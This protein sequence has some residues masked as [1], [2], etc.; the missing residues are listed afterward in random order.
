MIFSS[1]T[2]VFLFLPLTFV[3][4]L[5]V[6]KY[7][8]NA[9]LLIASLIFYAWGE[10]IFVLLML[11][12]GFVNYLFALHLKGDKKL[13]FWN[14]FFNIGLLA[15]F[16]Y[17]DFLIS[18]F[19]S[20]FSLSI[21]LLGLPLPVGISFYTFQTM[22]YTID[23]YRREIPPQKN[24]FDLLLYITFFPQ[25]IAGPIVVYKDIAE[26]I[27]NRRMTRKDVAQGIERFVYGLAKKLII[28]N[29]AALMVDK[30][31]A[32]K[33]GGTL[34]AWVAAVCYMLQIYYDFSG[35][36]D[37]AIGMGQMFGFYFKENF[38]YPYTATSIVN[39]WRRW[40][41]SLS[42]WFLD[43]VYIPLG[44]NRK[45]VSR[46]VT[47]KIFV[48]FLTGIWHGAAW[49]FI[50]WGLYHGFFLLLE[51]LFLKP[52]KWPKVL[53]HT[54]VIIVVMVG[55]VL[56]RSDTF[57]QA[58]TFIG[59]M[60]YYV[61]TGAASLSVVR[62]L[63]TPYFMFTMFWGILFSTPLIRKFHLNRPSGYIISA[64]VWILCLLTLSATTYN[65]FIY[66]RF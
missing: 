36:S 9:V 26:Q 29:S 3:L 58:F 25:L 46:E 19:N 57:L 27:K 17:S 18:T 54:Y 37:M 32:L 33:D 35:Y 53:C 64:A 65:P 42:S 28:A 6:P 40:H 55:F 2:F 5:I 16:K 22:S 24:F 20:I 66:F 63:S 43:Y 34:S 39:F 56:F 62:S 4:T 12:C 41:I 61:P 45:G 47:N 44:G 52:E 31:F 51:K 60:F 38:H 11:F 23:V 15:V 30:L 8:R 50:I 59:N 48:F 10:P 14:V 49:T 7:W 21:P 13:L 1:A